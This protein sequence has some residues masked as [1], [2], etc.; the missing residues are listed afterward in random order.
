VCGKSSEAAVKAQASSQLSAAPAVPASTGSPCTPIPRFSCIG[1]T[2]WNV[3]S[4]R[5]AAARVEPPTPGQRTARPHAFEPICSGRVD[6]T[7]VCKL[8]RL[9]HQECLRWSAAC[10]QCPSC[11]ATPCQPSGCLP[12]VQPAAPPQERVRGWGGPGDLRSPGGAVPTVLWQH[13]V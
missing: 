8:P 11:P 13:N 3:S 9:P 12:G 4:V 6:S 2:S 7:L 10:H 5:P 1:G